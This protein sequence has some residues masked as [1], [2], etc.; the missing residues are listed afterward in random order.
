VV[1]DVMRMIDGDSEWLVRAHH[2][3]VFAFVLCGTG[4]CLAV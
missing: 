3:L 1:E 2:W 4:A